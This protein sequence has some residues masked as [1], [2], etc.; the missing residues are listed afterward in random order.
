MLLPRLLL[1][2]LLALPLLFVSRIPQ[3]PG[4]KSSPLLFENPPVSW[5]QVVPFVV[6]QFCFVENTP[7]FLDQVLSFVVP[8][9]CVVEDPP[10]I[11][12][13]SPLLCL[14]I[15]VAWRCPW[16]GRA[17]LPCKI[18]SSCWQCLPL[19]LQCCTRAAVRFL[20]VG[21][22]VLVLSQTLLN[23]WTR[24]RRYVGPLYTYLHINRMGLMDLILNR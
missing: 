5:D 22:W 11:M 21:H 6:W 10:S 13:S 17:P 15:A 12:G 19:L 24:V 3:F 4:M 16:L 7:A 2:H 9:L 23:V 1:P 8:L 18:H 14:L 20:P